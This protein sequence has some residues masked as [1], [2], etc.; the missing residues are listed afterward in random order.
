MTNNETTLVM[1]QKYI[2]TG[3]YGDKRVLILDF[4]VVKSLA[5]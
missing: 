4:I 5:L 2:P 3:I 1:V